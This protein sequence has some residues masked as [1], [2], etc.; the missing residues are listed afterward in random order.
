MK[1]IGWSKGGLKIKRFYLI[2]WL[3]LLFVLVACTNTETQSNTITV[4][5]LTDREEA[6]LSINT[7][8]SFV[9]DFNVD[10]EYEEVSVWVEKYEF[11]QLV[12]DNISEITTMVEKSGSIIFTTSKTTGDSS[13]KTFNIGVNDEGG[14]SSMTSVDKK[15]AN[16][17]DMSS[18]WG[19]FSEDKTLNG[20]ATVL[21]GIGY[22]SSDFGMSSFTNDFYDDMEAHMD[23]LEEYD[24]AYVLKA[25]FKK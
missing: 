12:K 20:K 6:I 17:T 23:E 18:V 8:Q 2:I 13:E 9:F 7:E 22:S 4:A 3:S 5:E 10:N 21:A 25:E 15:T 16:L 24:V 1:G 11:G 19:N 14:S